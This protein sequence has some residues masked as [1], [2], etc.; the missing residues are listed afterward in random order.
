METSTESKYCICPV[1]FF[2]TYLYLHTQYQYQHQAP[3]AQKF[4]GRNCS[5][6]PPISDPF[7]PQLLA[8]MDSLA[9]LPAMNP[10]TPG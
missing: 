6:H 3:K 1:L 10:L 5:N 7:Q 8:H 9:G 4:H 2:A